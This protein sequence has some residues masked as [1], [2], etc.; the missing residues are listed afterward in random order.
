[1]MTTPVPKRHAIDVEVVST[2]CAKHVP[3][4]CNSD[5]S[6][7]EL[8]IEK[9][10]FGQSNPTYLLKAGGKK[11]VLRK[12]P[13]GKL[14]PSAHAIEREYKVMKALNQTRVPVPQVYAL[15]EDSSL[16]GTPFFIM[17][18]IEGRVF[19][20]ATLKSL[21]KSQRFAV[22]SEAMRVLGLM[23][24]VDLEEVGLSDYG[25]K[26]DYC[27]RQVRRWS[28]QYEASKLEPNPN[29]DKLK[30]WLNS[31]EE[32]DT[33]KVTLTHGD[34]TFTNM[35]FHPTEMRIIA[36]L[37]WEL[38]TIGNPLAD[39]AY[40]C[41]MYH[42]PTSSYELA[43]GLEGA[44]LKKLGLPTEREC[45]N[46]YIRFAQHDD[47]INDWHYYLGI[48]LYRIA[49]I[50]QG[51]VKRAHQGNA[52]NQSKKESR[53]MAGF[54]QVMSKC[55]INVMNK[56]NEDPLKEYQKIPLN[57]SLEPFRHL[58]SQKFFDYRAKLLFFQDRYIL[59]AHNKLR[60]WKAD[61][62]RERWNEPDFYH[63]LQMK[64]KAIGL[65]N[66]WAPK[67]WKD[68][69]GLTN[70][71]YA[72]LCEIMGR[73][74]AFFPNMCNCQAPDTGNMEVL[75]RY[76]SPTQ[77]KKW[78]APLKNGEITSCF[79]MTEPLVA[80]SDARNISCSIVAQGDEYVI[81][82]RKWWTSGAM[83]SK[84]RICILMGKTDPKASTYRQ[85]SM[86]L[87]PM[88][89]P[90]IKIE[91][92]LTVFGS[93][94]SPEGHAEVS[95]NNVRVP[96]D[97]LLLGE[98]RGFEI[99]QGRLGPG[100]IH[101]CMRTIG[102]A[103]LALETMIRRVKTRTAFGRPLEMM[104]TIRADIAESRMEIDQARLLTL[105]AAHAMDTIGNKAART[106]IASIKIIAPRVALKVIDRAIQAH[107]GAGVCQDFDLAAMYAGLRTL[108]LA[109]GPDEVHR[110]T[111][112]KIEI[113]KAK[114]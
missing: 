36:V 58:F 86:I 56:A 44:D 23:H 53:L 88:D 94:D 25:R 90:G 66:L 70:L 84:C 8:V 24:Q 3:G 34:Y 85:Q 10:S 114:L 75:V 113:R 64:A 17:E 6:I 60:K 108:R 96:K 28:K 87:V 41:K 27:R 95:F 76:A 46:S 100:R 38:S 42:M 15:C 5:G 20:T 59:P 40:F 79:G 97:N 82:G 26:G 35:M 19:K 107:G 31:Y 51:V 9:F 71:E 92:A 109:D 47:Y 83:N 21:D 48:G 63:G 37:D 52:S 2:F 98:G 111:V 18:F 91:R 69:P 32:Q 101:H 54:I 12:K 72:P 89:S 99:A 104:G 33:E 57:P 62:T 16:L 22:Y 103:E 112:A 55:G 30:D 81:N 61:E 50:C 106:T 65:W 78:L 13:S 105:S 45:I 11:W 67:H 1:M 77:Q 43:A 29:L 74:G 68:G 73:Y 4:F 93:D 110:E 49:A 7:P 39:L 80:S 102:A 14:L